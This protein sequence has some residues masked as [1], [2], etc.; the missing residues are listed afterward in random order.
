[1][2]EALG[3]GAEVDNLA[4]AISNPKPA[5]VASLLRFVR[6]DSAARDSV[7]GADAVVVTVGHNDLAYNRLDD[8]CHV[9]VRGY[10]SRAEWQGW[11]WLGPAIPQRR[12]RHSSRTTRGGCVFGRPHQ[13]RLGRADD[14]G[15]KAGE[16]A[17]QRPL[18]PNDAGQGDKQPA[19]SSASP[20][21]PAI[22]SLAS[23]STSQGWWR[24]STT[25]LQP[26]RSWWAMR[27]ACSRPTCPHSSANNWSSAVR[28]A[29]QPAPPPGCTPS[30]A[31]QRRYRWGEQAHPRNPQA[32][33][34][35]RPRWTRRCQSLDPGVPCACRLPR[36]TGR[37]W[38]QVEECSAGWGGNVAVPTRARVR[39]VRYSET[40]RRPPWP[41]RRWRR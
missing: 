36:P 30:P 23:K 27:W 38:S 26:P 18:G 8:P 29:A 12:G 25:T 10:L 34:D 24:S 9:V 5:E 21:P 16:G 28:M 11:E 17:D 41:R 19:T 1:M 3:V 6:R 33:R 32:N 39:T 37:C 22:A 20:R 40:H 35:G 4:W 13:I 15:P 7:A 31:G 14:L 2:R